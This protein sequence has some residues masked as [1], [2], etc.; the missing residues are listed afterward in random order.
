MSGRITYYHFKWGSGIN[1]RNVACV[2][3]DLFEVVATGLD[4][5]RVNEKRDQNFPEIIFAFWT[6]DYSIT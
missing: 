1:Q 6:Y 5:T 4:E 3:T 2:S